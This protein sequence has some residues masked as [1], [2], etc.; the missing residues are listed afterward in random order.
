MQSFV[1]SFFAS[2]SLFAQ[3]SGAMFDAVTVK[4]SPP[5][6]GAYIRGCKGGPG[7]GDPVLWRCTNATIS[8][9]IT[10]AYEIKSYQLTAPDWTSSENYEIN[11]SL[12]LDTTKEQFRD[13]IR[14]LLSGRFK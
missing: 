5:N 4:A 14:N 2:A 9:L 6:G 11:A 13:M 8:M 10:R 3:T 12:P 7:T 1:L